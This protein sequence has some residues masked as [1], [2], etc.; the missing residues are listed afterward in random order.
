MLY[1]TTEDIGKTIIM[2]YLG[3][4]REILETTFNVEEDKNNFD[5]KH[6]EKTELKK[7]RV[8]SKIKNRLNLPLVI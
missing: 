2:G 5:G 6:Q 1:F 4:I 7:W 8:K 3:R